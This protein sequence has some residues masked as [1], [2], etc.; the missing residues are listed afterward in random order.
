M[1][2]PEP[3]T[4]KTFPLFRPYKPMQIINGFLMVQTDERGG[5]VLSPRIVFLFKSDH[6][7]LFWLSFLSVFAVVICDGLRS[8][9]LHLLFMQTKYSTATESHLHIM[10]TLFERP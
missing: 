3:G 9:L 8:L 2:V 10:Y 1:Y 5:L 7:R 4:E 6:R